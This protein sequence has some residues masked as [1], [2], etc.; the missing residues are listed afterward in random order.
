M[1]ETFLS[2]LAAHLIGDF[3]LQTGWI[4]K[5]KKQWPALL[6]HVSIITIL[7]MLILGTWHPVIIP[8]IAV[9]HLAVDYVKA[10]LL[11]DNALAFTSDQLVHIAI[12]ALLAYYY[13]GTFEQGTIAGALGST[14]GFY[15]EILVFI[16][17]AIAC[18]PTGAYL[19]RKL[20][21]PFS[22]ELSEGALTGLTNGGFWIGCLERALVFIFVVSGNPEGIGL[23][24]A[25]KS[26]LRFG[27]IKDGKERKFA[28]Y[29]IIGTFLSFAWSLAVASAA[30]EAMHYWS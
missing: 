21:A 23:L 16:A 1:A 25:A 20:M 14:V 3:L 24:I 7:S 12:I 26:I 13:P 4:I 10:N 29:V 17:G 19:I 11:K 30:R 9:T 6:I 22:R 5:N 18:V 15:M 28:E 2:L 27:E 8:V